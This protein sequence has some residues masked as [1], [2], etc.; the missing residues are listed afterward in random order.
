MTMRDGEVIFDEDAYFRTFQSWGGPV[1]EHLAGKAER[2]ESLGRISAGFDTGDLIANIGTFYTA[3]E[4]SQDLEAHVGVNPGPVKHGAGY[5]VMHHE[6]TEPHEIRPRAR[7]ALRFP[8][9]GMVVFAARVWHPG[10]APVK[11][12]TRWLRDVM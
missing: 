3:H 11:F 1:G 9:G 5:A 6:G 2:L 7:R 12:L 4:S 10:T 8:K